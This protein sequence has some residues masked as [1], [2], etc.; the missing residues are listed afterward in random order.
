MAE[1]RFACPLCGEGVRLPV[2]TSTERA[3]G[4]LHVTF[5]ADLPRTIRAHVV[6][7]HTIPFVAP[8][9]DSD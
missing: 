4:H 3:D 2:A 7:R 6:A 9:E 8:T 5:S 1:L